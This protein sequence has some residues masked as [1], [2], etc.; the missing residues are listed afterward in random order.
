MF[1]FGE[2]EIKC[3]PRNGNASKLFR[4]I[5][6]PEDNPKERKREKTTGGVLYDWGDI[7]LLG[8]E[9]PLGLTIILNTISLWYH[10]CF[11]IPFMI[12]LGFGAVHQVANSA[13]I[14]ISVWVSL[15]HRAP[16]LHI[17]K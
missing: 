5:R 11:T 14:K 12:Y 16:I 8:Q 7:A 6:P 15:G 2:G 10:Q 4:N 1:V 3:S 13:F 17:I 9:M